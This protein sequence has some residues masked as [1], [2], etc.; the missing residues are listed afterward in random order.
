MKAP[1]FWGDS[2]APL[3][4]LLAPLGWLHA[5]VTAFRLARAH[6]WRAPIPVICVG[7]LTAGGAG[8]TPVV[9]AITRLLTAR[10]LVPAILSRGYGG[11]LSGPVRVDTALHMAADV[12]DEPLMLARD[13]ICWIARERAEGAR[14][15]AAAGAG[16]IVMDDGLQNPQ[17]A[18]DLRLI[19]VDGPTGFG[20]R[21]AIPAGPLREAIAAGIARADA[22]IVVGPDCHDL[23]S[24]FE[25]RLRVIHAALKPLDPASLAGRD[26]IAFAG[27]GRPAKFRTTLEEAGARIVAFHGFPDHHPYGDSELAGLAAEAKAAGV[28]LITTEKDWTRLSPSW[29]DQVG[30]APVVLHWRDE[31]QIIDLL[32]RL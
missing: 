31:G 6:P 25:G 20:N 8:K 14:A 26:F 16:A 27:I 23:E 3:G 7:N 15:I 19:V 32:S 13:A 24:E 11:R 10:G 12:G 4:R 2:S 5:E 17:L 1:G 9:R 30:H 22:L 28:A 18:N 21:R 29:R